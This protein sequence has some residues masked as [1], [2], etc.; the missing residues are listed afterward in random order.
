MIKF[1]SLEDL[2]NGTKRNQQYIHKHYPEFENYL[3]S[4]FD[5]VGSWIEKLYCYFYKIDKTPLCPV[6][7]NPVKFHGFIYG[8]YTYCSPACVGRDKYVNDKKKRTCLEHYGVKHAT[9]SEEIRNKVKQTCLEKYGVEH[10]MYLQSSKNKIKQTCLERYGI[11]SPFQSQEIRNKVKQTNLERYGVEHPFQSK[12]IQ[13]KVK[14]TCLEKYGAEQ[15]FQSDIIK[16]KIKETNLEKYGVEKP[17]QSQII[18]DK[19]RQTCLDKYGVVYPQKDYSIRNKMSRSHLSQEVQNKTKQTC[20]ERYGVENPSQSQE[21]LNKI[22]NTKHQNHTFSS[23]QIET[24]FA[25][26]L[27]SESIKYI[28][29]YRSKEYPFNCDFYLPKYDLYIEIQGTWMHGIHPFNT[30]SDRDTLESWK[31]K[32]KKSYDNA[33]ETWTIRDV[34]KR[35]VAKQNQLNYLEIFSNDIDEVVECFEKFIHNSK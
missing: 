29:Q 19:S 34:K 20:L 1:P 24:E 2:N 7:G 22:N 5:F 8:Y 23:S 30:E 26:Y 31:S 33:I 14:Q 28:R 35:E 13:N 18:R 21:I 3:L 27:D 10:P 15:P 11:V 9:Q 12:N 6:C 17:F 4:H 32:N 16:D 25:T